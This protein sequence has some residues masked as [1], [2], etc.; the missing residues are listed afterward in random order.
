MEL[1]EAYLNSE[2]PGSFGDI[3]AIHRALKGR[4][5]RREI[6]KWLEMKDSY[7][8][9]KPVRH[10]FKRNR[11]IVKGINDQFQSDLVDMQSSSKYNNGFKYLLT[12]IEI[13]SEYAWA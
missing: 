12:C 7:S 5:K 8:L 1:E 10:K 2:H 9:H 11:V 3:N 13:F 6:K 4:V